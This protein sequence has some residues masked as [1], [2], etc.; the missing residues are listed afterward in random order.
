MIWPTGNKIFYQISIAMQ[1]LTPTNEGNKQDKQL[2]VLWDFIASGPL[3]YPF[4]NSYF[5]N[6]Y[7][8][9]NCRFLTS[10]HQTLQSI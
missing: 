5:L 8:I 7:F 10:N 9:T 4:N 3:F 6:I 1:F 2:W